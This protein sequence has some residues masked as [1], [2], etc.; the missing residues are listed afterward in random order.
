MKVEARQDVRF[1]K[2]KILVFSAFLIKHLDAIHTVI[3][4]NALKKSVVISFD[5]A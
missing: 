1:I 3:T 4:V 5:R 2:Q